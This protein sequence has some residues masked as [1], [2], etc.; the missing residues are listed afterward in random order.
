MT[1]SK[2]INDPDLGEIKLSK[3]K[4][5]KNIRIR[6]NA[7][8]KVHVTMPYRIGFTEAWAFVQEKHEWIKKQ[9]ESFKLSHPLIQNPNKA[10]IEKELRS[11]AHSYLPFRLKELATKYG[12]QYQRLSIRNTRTR[13]GSCSS[14][15]NINLCI[16][17]MRLPEELI[18]YVILHELAHTVHKN[19][20]I[21]FWNFLS[22]LLGTDAKA[23]DKKLKA[24]KTLL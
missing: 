17:L 14:K 9:I 16:H 1:S 13:W 23:I 3:Y 5:A 10:E 6:V 4:G 8:T 11:K 2:T 24:Y 19:H 18:D 20:S 21:K 15:N 22:L 7:N 12:L